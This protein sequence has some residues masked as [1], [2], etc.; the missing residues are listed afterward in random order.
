MTDVAKDTTQLFDNLSTLMTPLEVAEFFRVTRRTVYRWIDAKKI[1]THKV[2][3]QLRIER[4]E[5]A[6]L[7]RQKG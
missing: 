1:H 3:G 2:G 4:E 6:K 7:L 5:V